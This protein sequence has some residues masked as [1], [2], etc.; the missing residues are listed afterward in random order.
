M[1]ITKK[2]LLLL[3][4]E[5]SRMPEGSL[6]IKHNKSYYYFYQ[7]IN[8]SQIPISH[9]LNLV[10]R[11]A[12]KKYLYWVINN[13][14]TEALLE[15][16]VKAGLSLQRI[17][18]TPGQYRWVTEDYKAN[19][20]WQENLKYKTK[21]GIAMRSK[22]ER[23]IGN[24]LEYLGVPYRYDMMLK[25]NVS[26]IVEGICEYLSNLKHWHYNPRSLCS[27]RDGYCVWNVPEELQWM[28]ASG[29][30]WRSYNIAAKTVTISVDFSIL[31]GDGSVLLW[32]HAGLCLNPVYRCNTSERIFVL[33]TTAFVPSENVLFTTEND[34]LDIEDIDELIAS[35]I[36][37]RI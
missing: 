8:S 11:L 26:Q 24:R 21:S 4:K 18:L 6:H 35:R 25:I 14:S 1:T 16:Y 3:K 30:I 22:S 36:L 5:Y 20:G 9:D 27:Y 15:K 33:R 29:S 2:R 7:Y 28:N 32:E 23:D 10:Y 12:R 13:R 37:P 34:I 31:L 17:V 19:T